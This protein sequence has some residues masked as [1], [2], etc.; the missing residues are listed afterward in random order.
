M[1]ASICRDEPIL[2]SKTTPLVLRYLLHAHSG[3]ADAERGI[4]GREAIL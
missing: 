3:S 2:L 4:F 1:G